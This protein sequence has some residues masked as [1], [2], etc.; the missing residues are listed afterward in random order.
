MPE[1]RKTRN[2]RSQAAANL[3]RPG[4]ATSGA[5][6]TQMSANNLIINYTAIPMETL[7]FR[8][9]QRRLNQSGPRRVL[10]TRLQESHSL[11]ANAAPQVPDQ[12]QP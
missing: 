11:A 6:P 12:L 7:R 3:T 9:S 5:G 4:S 8:L 2:N 10:I 1:P